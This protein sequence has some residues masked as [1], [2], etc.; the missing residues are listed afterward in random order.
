MDQCVDGAVVLFVHDVILK[1]M[2]QSHTLKWQ[3]KFITV[4]T[5]R[6]Q[7]RFCLIGLAEQRNGSPSEQQPVN[8]SFLSQWSNIWL[9]VVQTDH[10]DPHLVYYLVTSK[11]QSEA[12]PPSVRS[13]CICCA[14]QAV[15]AREKP[16]SSLCASCQENKGITRNRLCKDLPEPQ[17]ICDAMTNVVL[18]F[19]SSSMLQGNSVNVVHHRL[20]W[21]QQIC[22]N[23]SGCKAAPITWIPDRHLPFEETSLCLFF[24]E[25]ERWVGLPLQISQSS[26][27]EATRVRA[28]H[29]WSLQK[30]YRCASIECATWNSI[31]KSSCLSVW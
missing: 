31:A 25:A 26:L 5:K 30:N 28:Q 24:R 9:T 12:S 20:R 11:L 16:A 7:E 14:R 19:L 10:C 23:L 13:R 3:S 29:F 8:V 27:H 1:L 4:H 15:C 21:Q 6:T 18:L 17:R 22:Q 2:H